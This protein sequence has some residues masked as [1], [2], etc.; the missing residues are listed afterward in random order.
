MRHTLSVRIPFA[1]HNARK[2]ICWNC[3]GH[4][5]GDCVSECFDRN[6][7]FPATQRG[8]WETVPEPCRAGGIT[9]CEDRDEENTCIWELVRFLVTT[10]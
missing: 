4:A 5:K 10:E 8:E 6:G 2:R 1:E 9:G 3:L 7:D